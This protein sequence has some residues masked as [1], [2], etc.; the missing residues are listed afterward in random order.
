MRTQQI[1]ASYKKIRWWK[2]A[3][4]DQANGNKAVYLSAEP[5]TSSFKG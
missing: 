4:I 3:L 5:N 2:A 1:V